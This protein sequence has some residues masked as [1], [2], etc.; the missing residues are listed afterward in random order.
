MILMPAAVLVVVIL[1]AIAFDLSWVYSVQREAIDAAESAA[2]DAAT[3]GVDP[4]GIGAGE[5]VHLDAGRVE[6]AVDR[7]LA[8][9]HPRGYQPDRTT[10]AA[11]AATATITVTIAC[12][13]D[14]VFARAI[15]GTNHGHDLTASG[16]ATLAQ[17]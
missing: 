13:V 2:N 12:H 3:F 9:H 14:D 15:P 5:G 6:R 1:A 8:V 17:R 7:S 16:S 4:G 11:D 10:I